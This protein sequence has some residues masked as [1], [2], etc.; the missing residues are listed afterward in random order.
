MEKKMKKLI[1]TQYDLSNADSLNAIRKESAQHLKEIKIIYHPAE[2]AIE[3]YYKGKV[4]ETTNF[5]DP[6]YDDRVLLDPQIHGSLKNRELQ[7]MGVVFQINTLDNIYPGC[8]TAEYPL[9]DD[10][11]MWS[12]ITPNPIWVQFNIDHNELRDIIPYS[13]TRHSKVLK[14][15]KDDK[16]VTILDEGSMDA[17]D[18]AYERHQINKQNSGIS[19]Y[20]NQYYY[21]NIMLNIGYPKTV[22]EIIE[23]VRNYKKQLFASIKP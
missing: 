18:L 21:I 11:I 5:E 20:I 22:N 12:V 10:Y 9:L 19:T 1:K 23:A 6:E 3:A 7:F 8:N 15:L 13:G 17:G 16:D 2:N 4:F 14:Y